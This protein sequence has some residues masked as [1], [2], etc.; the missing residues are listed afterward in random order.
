MSVLESDADLCY[1]L[2]GRND[3]LR[4]D[5]ACRV[6]AQ[7]PAEESSA[8]TEISGNLGGSTHL[9]EDYSQIIIL[10]CCLGFLRREPRDQGIHNVE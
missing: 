7:L 5:L 10:L 4:K 9:W 6:L 3:L 2:R 8:F 1:F